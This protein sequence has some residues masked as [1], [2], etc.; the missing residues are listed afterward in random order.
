MQK[1][2]E[3]IYKSIV[4]SYDNSIYDTLMI[5]SHK[6]MIKPRVVEED[7]IKI[8]EESIK[9]YEKKITDISKT[10]SY[11]WHE[12]DA[13]SK[14]LFII[15]FMKQNGVKFVDKSKVREVLKRKLSQ[16]KVGQ[17]PKNNL[18]LRVKNKNK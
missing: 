12:L 9:K 17:K 3:E 4:N 1:D 16:R 13:E 14:E 5:E 2:L 10:K 15:N 8:L 6:L 7:Q 11:Y 18:K